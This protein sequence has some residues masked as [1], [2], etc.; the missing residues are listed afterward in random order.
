MGRA[1]GPS[2]RFVLILGALTAL[3]PASIDMYLPSFPELARALGAAPASVQLTL[4]AYLVG[5]AVGQA[6]YGPLA[7]RLGRRRPLMGGLA[8]YAV[9]SAGCA[10][11]PR[12]DVL[13]ALRFVQAL[14]GAACLVIPRAIVRDRFDPQAS[15]R[16]YSHLM[17][18]V[19][20]A[21]ILA[22][23]VGGQIVH[24]A[25]W[26]AVF[27]VLAG[28]GV[29]GLLLTALALPESSPRAAAPSA[30]LRDYGWL[31][32]DRRFVGFAACGGLAM[33]GMFAY[34]ASSPF[35]LIEL[36]GVPPRAFGWIFG[37]NAAALIAA[38]QVN[39]AM[40]LRLRSE[41]ILA[42]SITAGAVIGVALVG[43]AVTS[44]GGLPVLLVLLFAYL[45]SRGFLQPN[46]VACAL[47]DHPQRAASASALF[48]VVQ[49]GGATVASALVGALHD[50]TARPMALV[51]GGSSVLALVA[52]VA[53][54]R[55]R[56]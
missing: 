29:G 38:S 45:A 27:G 56:R 10:L 7:D 55:G 8:L 20:V 33:A 32:T 28:L 46:A 37:G 31:L 4:G 14:G 49:F 11:A 34:I 16:V 21:P 47:V 3:T 39:G 24:V 54:A 48:G 5:L 18:V 22:P 1:P 35:V 42:R 52:Y 40:L 17:L 44:V 26:R 9:A 36:Y 13:I 41:T 30:G 50:G 6:A 23:L 53:L 12:V 51:M 15:A 25:G 43:V 19:G 2:V